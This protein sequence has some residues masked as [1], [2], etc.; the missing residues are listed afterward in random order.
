MAADSPA[1][2]LARTLEK[3]R[4]LKPKTIIGINDEGEETRIPITGMRGRYERA[5][6]ALIASDAVTAKLLDESGGVLEVLNVAAASAS[7]DPADNGPP[8]G[9]FS[10]TIEDRIREDRELRRGAEVDDVREL[11]KIALDAADRARAADLEGLKAARERDRDIMREQTE[12]LRTVTQAAVGMMQ[13]AAERAERL[14]AMLMEQ[15]TRHA[16]E[17]RAIAMQLEAEREERQRL[18][19]QNG[20]NSADKMIER[21]IFGE[22]KKEEPKKD[23]E[24]ENKPNGQATPTS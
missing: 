21:L 16:K 1:I 18:Q 13:T 24:G 8:E 10:P 6:R 5:G 11:V 23:A 14:E 3:L 17:L 4:R 22:P 9:T 7:S 12:T 19:E 15:N 2:R 20:D